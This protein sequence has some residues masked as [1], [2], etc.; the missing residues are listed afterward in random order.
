M[1]AQVVKLTVAEVATTM[2][3]T[4]IN[5]MMHIKRGLLAGEEIDGAWY[6]P[7]DSLASYLSDTSRGSNG[8]VC[9]AKSHCGSGCS[10]SCG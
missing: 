8:S 2:K 9:K 7:A 5:V 6:V 4:P 1:T 10:S 3:T